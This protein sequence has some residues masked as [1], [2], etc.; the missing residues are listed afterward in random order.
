MFKNGTGT[1]G[2]LV[3]SCFFHSV[4]IHNGFS[5]MTVTQVKH[6]NYNPYMN[7]QISFEKQI[8]VAYQF[9]GS[10]FSF[11]MMVYLPWSNLR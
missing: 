3:P 11:Y 8:K 9:Y 2:N 1:S 5:P 4:N 10:G 6:T 7:N